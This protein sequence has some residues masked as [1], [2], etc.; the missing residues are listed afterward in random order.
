[1]KQKSNTRYIIIAIL[2]FIVSVLLFSKMLSN[3]KSSKDIVKTNLIVTDT[4]RRHDFTKN[5]S[6]FGVVESKAK[7]SIITMKTGIIS[8][9]NIEE[10]T[11]VEKGT[12]LFTLDAPLIESNIV[13]MKNKISDLEERI[14]FIKQKTA[15][16]NN[17]NIEKENPTPARDTLPKLQ[18]ELRSA[19]E[20]MQL[21]EKS[22]Q[23]NAAAQ[24]VFTNRRVSA[25]QLV[26][27]GDQLGEIISVNNLRI[28]AT[29]FP[30]ENTDLKDKK[31][32]IN[33]SNGD[34]IPGIISNVLPQRTS[35][36]AAI[37]LIASS[38]SSR[39]LY[40]GDT[41]H[42]IVELIK[43][44]NALCVQQ[45][46]VVRDEQ[47]QSYVFI[48]DASGYHKQ[49]VQTGI[50]SNNLIEIVSGL[51]ETDKIVVQ[52]AYELFYQD[53]NKIYKVAD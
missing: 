46:A 37:V 30:P 22:L 41:V 9:V 39:I 19:K 25:G 21:L 28:R 24:G 40:P 36:G 49:N 5:Y 10:G 3:K 13:S 12:L 43:D 18:D 52:G 35:D 11:F 15:E 6:W 51:N 23:I 17:N 1:M 29:L 7:A 44:K 38:D 27:K 14:T 31:A 34:F 2:I 4:P 8:S 20:R 42:G 53:F 16:K 50:I 48:K 33:F 47:E 32:M 45:S 26:Q